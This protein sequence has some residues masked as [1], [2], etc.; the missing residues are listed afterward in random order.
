MNEIDE[1]LYHHGILGMKWGIRRYQRKDGSLTAAGKAKRRGDLNDGSTP[2]RKQKKLDKKISKEQARSKSKEQDK[3]ETQ[4]ERRAR[5][6][7]STNAS[8]IYKN[9]DVLTTSEI[10]ERIDRI[11]TEKQLASIANETKKTGM[12]RINKIIEYGKKV[13]EAYDLVSKSPI[14]DMINKKLGLVEDKKEFDLN[15]VWKNRNKLSS[16]VLK[17]A[18]ERISNERKIEEEIKRRQK[19]EAEEKTKKDAIKE[20][21]KA[22]KETK[23]KIN[24]ANE[25]I[26]KAKKKAEKE[27]KKR[28]K[29]EAKEEQRKTKEEN[30]TYTGEVFGEGTSRSKWKDSKERDRWKDYVDVDFVDVDKPPSSVNNNTKAIGQNYISLLLEDKRRG[31]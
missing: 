20:A 11:N 18:T 10:R 29:K 19:N 23:D 15:S 14:G 30:K 25:D 31:R 21:E 9:R 4:E 2:S 6:L 22:K 7:K 5:I 27:D 1:E 28:N 17:D 8:E 16:K 12:D 3:T 13:N 26:A 24:K